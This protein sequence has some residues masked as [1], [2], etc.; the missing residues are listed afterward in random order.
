MRNIR[1]VDVR[2][3]MVRQVCNKKACLED[4]KLVNLADIAETGEVLTKNS[5]RGP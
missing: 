1:L 5:P 4:I 2:V 3:G